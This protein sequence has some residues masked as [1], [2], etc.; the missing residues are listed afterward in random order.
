MWLP[1]FGAEEFCGCCL[2]FPHKL[3]GRGEFDKPS[4]APRR[5]GWVSPTDGHALSASC[6]C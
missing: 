2:T 5:G 1:T 6:G 3:Q 4:R